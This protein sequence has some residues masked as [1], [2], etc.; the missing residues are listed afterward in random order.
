MVMEGDDADA[1]LLLLNRSELGN[2]FFGL[3][4]PANR[5]DNQQIGRGGGFDGPYEGG[6]ASGVGAGSF[7][8]AYEVRID[9]L[10]LEDRYTGCFAS[11]FP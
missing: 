8:P 4:G 7:P 5:I 10:E 11:E 3:H 1:L 2:A 6:G 9:R